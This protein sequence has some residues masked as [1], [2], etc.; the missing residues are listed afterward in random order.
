MKSI[1]FSCVQ[2]GRRLLTNA[3]FWVLSATLVVIVLVVD[4]ALPKESAAE[5]YRLVT[6]G[7][8]A[9]LTEGEPMASLEELNEAVRAGGAIGVSFD[10]DGVTIVHSGYS[11]QTLNAMALAL[12]GVEPEAVHTTQLLEDAREIPQNLRSVPIFVCFEALMVGFIL[13]GGLM[14]AEK[15]EGTVRAL[16]VSPMGATRYILAKTLLFSLIGTVYASLLVLPTI[17]FSIHWGE[18]LL[19]SFFGTAVFTMI[20]LAYS[21][22]FHDMSGWFFSMVLLLSVNM[23]P[24]ISYSSPAYSPLWMKLI[25]S[26]PILMA[27]GGAL[28]GGA[29]DAGYT[30]LSIAVWS[31]F[32]FLLAL[33]M[34]SK[35][36]L[37]EVSA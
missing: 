14:L 19:L 21:A 34:V 1:L 12:Y 30:V 16:R 27:Y 6:Y 37:G 9:A 8:P 17:G 36:H 32:A 22:P 3:L 24:V 31:A 10:A 28:F 18:F 20:G 29:A 25:P 2:D 35:R 7:A 11:E 15:Q 5:E 33:R 13:G 23:L 26:Y 4:L